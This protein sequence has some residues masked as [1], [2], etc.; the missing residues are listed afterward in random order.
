MAFYVLWILGVVLCVFAIYYLYKNVVLAKDS[1]AF[2]KQFK[3]LHPGCELLT[4]NRGWVFFDVF[5]AFLLFS[6]GTQAQ[7]LETEWQTQPDRLCFWGIGIFYA[8]RTIHH[9]IS[10]RVLF[11]KQGF[12]WKKQE[13][14]YQTVQEITPYRNGWDI[15]IKGEV[16]LVPAKMGQEIQNRMDE[17]KK[18]RRMKKKT[19]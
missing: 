2:Q 6:F 12:A 17:W 1:F 7:M 5:L 3:R 11:Y 16:L 13:V 9:W 14:P 10:G 8:A 4:Y 18:H 15:K 19:G